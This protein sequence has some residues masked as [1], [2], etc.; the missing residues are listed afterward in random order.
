MRGNIPTDHS[1]NPVTHTPPP[2]FVRGRLAEPYVS[3][4]V[5][6]CNFRSLAFLGLLGFL[7]CQ[8]KIEFLATLLSAAKSPTS[9]HTTQSL[10]SEVWDLYYEFRGLG[11]LGQES[12]GFW[13]QGSGVRFGV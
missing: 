11:G 2:P 9:S 4:V 5:L 3:F 8:L 6:H 13:A 12:L 10:K 7:I 1:E